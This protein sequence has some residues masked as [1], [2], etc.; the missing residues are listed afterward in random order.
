MD[1]MAFVAHWGL[2]LAFSAVLLEQYGFPVLAATIL[3]AGGALAADGTMRPEI[4]LLVAL[5]ACLIADHSWFVIGRRHGRRIL[6]AVCR[7]S[8]SPD[9]C[10]RQADD[11]VARYGAPLLLAAKFI[12]G[13]SAVAIPTAAATGLSYPR[14]L[15]FDLLGCLVWC[16]AYIGAGMIFSRE[17]GRALAFMSL[18]GGWS[19]V[20]LGVVFGLYI[21]VKLAHRWRLRRLYRL[22]RIS[23]EEMRGLLASDP[24]LIVLDAR[25]SLARMDDSRTLPRS[26]FVDYDNALRMLPRDASDRTL[27][28]FCTCP[29]EASAALLAQRLIEAGYVRV[30]VLAGGTDALT[31]L[32]QESP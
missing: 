1:L 17:V 26:I 6:G 12:P 4:L 13:V 7:L 3:V 25:T 11:L 20:I 24:E 19:I 8:L 15:I 29:N 9:S 27:V 16:G 23:P 21:A 22:V 28:T 30:R 10:V 5:A 32:A 18:I 31:V 14:F 2:A